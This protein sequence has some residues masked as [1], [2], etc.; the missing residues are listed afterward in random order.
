M[1]LHTLQDFIEEN[2]KVSLIWPSKS[3]CGALVLFVK[4]KD[5]FLH[6]CIDYWGLNKITQKDRYPIPLISD[7]VDAPKK[8]RVYSKIDLHSAYHL[9]RITEGEEWKT[10]FCTRYRSY[11]WLVMPFG[12][13]NAPSAFQHLINEIFANMLDVWTVIYLDDILIY[14]DSITEHKKH[15]REVLQWLCTNRL[16]ALPT[17]CMFHHNKVEFLGFILGLQGVQIDNKKVSIIWE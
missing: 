6:L 15:V 14:S 12:L 1:E 2:I 13:T 4:K 8:A 10:A 11:E 5:R 3:P 7:L 16:Y 9:V 17:K